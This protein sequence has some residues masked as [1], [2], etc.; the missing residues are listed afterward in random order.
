MT[1]IENPLKSVAK[2]A[3]LVDRPI[4]V[5][6]VD[7]EE[8]NLE[9][10]VKH[11]KKAGYEAIPMSDGDQAWDYLNKNPEE[12]DIIL[13]D[14]MMPRMNGMEVLK[15]L[16]SR[17]DLQH[18][19]VILQTAS[20][21]AQELIG[22][23]EAGAYYYLTKPYAAEVLISIVNSAARD[24]RQKNKLRK[25]IGRKDVLF[26]DV[27]QKEEF[28]IR[29]IDEAQMLATHISN[30][31][32]DPAR[33]V[34]GIAALLTNAIEHGNLGIGYEQKSQLV[35]KG[36]GEW[37]KEVERRLGLPENANKKVVVQLAKEGK[38]I[39][40]H[41]KDQGQGFNWKTYMDFDPRRVTDPN[42]RGIAMAN[43]M[44]PGTIEYLGSGNEVVY[45][46]DPDKAAGKGG[47][48]P[49]SM[50]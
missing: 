29:T 16:K 23:I 13:L 40:I 34:V 48:S 14:K 15:K 5:M 8:F 33:V 49:S 31:Y 32:S 47:Q 1:I 27:I 26:S 20:V 43:I 45:T 17:P 11:L 44:V 3:N 37:E 39:S 28:S 50:F 36:Q 30:F 41:I 21:G 42:G 46:I 2:K 12:I 35:N 19:T 9:I 22:G 4:R 38:K 24:H 10:L 7:D 6:A 18:I 25:E